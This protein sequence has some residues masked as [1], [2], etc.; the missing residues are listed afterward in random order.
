MVPLVQKKQLDDKTR[1]KHCEQLTSISH[2]QYLTHHKSHIINYAQEEEE[3][4][5]YQLPIS[6]EVTLGSSHS[7]AVTC[8]DI[9]HSGSRLLTG[10]FGV[11]VY[12]CVCSVSVTVLM[13]MPQQ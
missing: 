12:V 3:D 11:N 10:V 4:D 13:Q 9:D 5:P 6:H 7:K 2:A 8:M 1:G